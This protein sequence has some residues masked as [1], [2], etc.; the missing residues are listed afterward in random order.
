MNVDEL[1]VLVRRARDGEEVIAD[2]PPDLLAKAR[3]ARRRNRVVMPLAAAASTLLVVASVT[4]IWR[5]GPASPTADATGTRLV[6]AHG[7][8]VRVPRAWQ[9]EVEVGSECPATSPRTIVFFVRD[10]RSPVGS[11]TVKPGASWP[12]V[13]SL[14]V[15]T[16]VTDAVPAES[17]TG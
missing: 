7:L 6:G 4:T 9:T 5:R 3:R 1:S 13:D 14:S 12:A 16:D 11:C 10:P 8:V 2:P 15:F 17:Q